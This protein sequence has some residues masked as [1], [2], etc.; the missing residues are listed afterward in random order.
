MLPILVGV[1][2]WLSIKLNPQPTDPVQ[3][4]IFLL[5]P[6]VL[7]VVMA[8][9]AA[10]LQLYWFVNNLLTIAQQK[11]LYYRYDHEMNP[12]TEVDAVVVKK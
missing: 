6:W 10:G 8:P 7:I 4:Q 11:W 5:M 1:S 9:F 3:A 12:P 2:Q